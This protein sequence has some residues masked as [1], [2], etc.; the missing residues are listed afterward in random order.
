MLKGAL[1]IE[2]L[3]VPSAHTLPMSW[4]YSHS[5]TKSKLPFSPADLHLLPED[6]LKLAESPTCTEPESL[7]T[8]LGTWKDWRNCYIYVYK[9]VR[10]NLHAMLTETVR[11]NCFLSVPY[12]VPFFQYDVDNYTYITEK[13]PGS[14]HTKPTVTSREQSVVRGWMKKTCAFHSIHF[15]IPVWFLIKQ[16]YTFIFLVNK[17]LRHTHTHTQKRIKKKQPNK[18]QT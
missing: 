12:R 1:P 15:Y 7:G 10:M 6:T 14:L 3:S 5:R 18:P 4:L 16:T 17:K 9:T 13:K 8:M 11:G 2:M